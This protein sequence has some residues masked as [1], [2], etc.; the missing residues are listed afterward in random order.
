MADT[1][2]NSP[3]PKKRRSWL[4]LLLG[5]VAVLVVLLVVVYFVAT[6]SAFLKGV[7]LPRAGKAMNANITVSDA[8]ISPFSQ[9]I[10]HDLKVQTTGTEPLVSAQEA[11]LRYSLMDIIRGNI[12]V[13]EIAVVSPRVV[14]VKN[15]DGTSNLDPIMK[16]QQ[17]QPQAAKP[18]PAKPSQPS[19]PLQVDI[20]K[21]D[22]SDATLRLQVSTNG[23]TSVAEISHLNVSLDN[24]KN[25]V[26]GKFTVSANIGVTNNP[27]TPAPAG[28]LAAKLNGSYDFSLSQDLKPASV[29][30]NTHLEVTK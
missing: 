25:G 28:L 10:L 14:L 8:S 19:K 13:D 9:V 15:P 29:K 6:S 17:A 24:V 20:K 1:K 7:V 27:P 12:R 18:A 26:A 3:A 11:R 16:A 30:G 2:V 23:G 22:F 21:I 4:R 5:I